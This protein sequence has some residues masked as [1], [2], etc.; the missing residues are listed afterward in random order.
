MNKHRRLAGCVP[1]KGRAEHLQVMLITSRRHPN[2]LVFPKGGVK[3]DESPESA[4]L[5]ETWEEAGIRGRILHRLSPSDEDKYS[6]DDEFCCEEAGSV[7]NL[8]MSERTEG[9]RNSEL[10]VQAC[11]WYVLEVWEEAEEWPE[12]GQRERL[13]F[14]LDKAQQLDN[15]RDNVRDLLKLLE[16][17]NGRQSM[18]AASPHDQTQCRPALSCQII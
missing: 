11:R 5:R 13:W 3:R 6:D 15:I 18:P 2:R 1:I 9:R 7:E 16:S 17:W 8:Q 10:A 12:K 14:S 4:A